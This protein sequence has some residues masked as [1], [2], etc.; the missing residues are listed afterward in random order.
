MTDRQVSFGKVQKAFPDSPCHLYIAAL[1]NGVQLLQ[2][3][4]ALLQNCK[5][6]PKPHAH[7]LVAPHVLASSLPDGTPW[8]E[9]RPS[10]ASSSLQQP[11]IQV[12]T[13]LGLPPPQPVHTTCRAPS[14]S[15]SPKASAICTNLAVTCYLPQQLAEQLDWASSLLMHQ[16]VLVPDTRLDLSALWMPSVP[17]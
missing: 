6:G 9:S 1:T 14:T 13:S 16:I 15:S 10:V 7:V 8:A 3:G 17:D 11:A 5:L 4:G 2:S 12:S